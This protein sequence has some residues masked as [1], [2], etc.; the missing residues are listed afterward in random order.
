MSFDFRYPPVGHEDAMY[1]ERGFAGMK[2]LE[3]ISYFYINSLLQTLRSPLVL[4][5]GCTGFTAEIELVLTLKQRALH[6]CGSGRM[7]VRL[8][9]PRGPCALMGSG[10]LRCFLSERAF[11][12]AA[13]ALWEECERYQMDELVTDLGSQVFALVWFVIVWR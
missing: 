13:M 12:A 5:T 9:S 1:S 4:S 6:S 11:R 2:C 7:E 3:R 10:F 8:G